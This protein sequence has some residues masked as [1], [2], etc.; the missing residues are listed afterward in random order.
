[1]KKVIA[2]AALNVIVPTICISL[3]ACPPVI[4]QGAKN[5]EGDACSALQVAGQLAIDDLKARG[6]A[7]A[8][9]INLAEIVL[10]E[11]VTRCREGVAKQRVQ[12]AGKE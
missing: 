1:M 6:T 10:N 5:L 7:N 4:S 8:N 11:A 2:I 9:E 3:T 12:D